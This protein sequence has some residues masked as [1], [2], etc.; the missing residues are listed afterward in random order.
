MVRTMM[1]K[2][3]VRGTPIVSVLCDEVARRPMRDIRVENGSVVAEVD[4]LDAASLARYP[5][6]LPVAARKHVIKWTARITLTGVVV[7]V[8]PCDDG[9]PLTV[10]E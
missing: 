4:E 6:D 2:E 7:V 8:D 5:D 10:R 3:P 9:V 1:T